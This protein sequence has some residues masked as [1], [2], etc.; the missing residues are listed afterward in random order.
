MTAQLSHKA[1]V[2]P[3]I[4]KYVP[5][6]PKIVKE[7]KVYA[8]DLDH[9]LIKPKSGG[10][11]S[12]TVDDWVFMSYGGKPG[13]QNS[14]NSAEFL[15]RIL[16]ADEGAHV[17]VFSN[18]GGVITVPPTSKSCLKYTG[19]IDQ[20][21]QDSCI[22]EFLDRIWLYASPKKPASLK[23]KSSSYR[24]AKKVTASK[25]SSTDVAQSLFESMRKPNSGMYE[26]FKKDFPGQFA[27]EYYCGDAAGR[28]SDFSDSDKCFAA[29]IGVRFSIPEDVFL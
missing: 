29:N 16:S 7:A 20:I 22:S 1:V 11:F 3:H 13:E 21:L 26:E 19:K 27:M 2:L 8:F 28:P 12:R 6:N 24:V 14:I 25:S 15:A 23:K 4:I 18:Q 9:T 10:R 5:K 17:V